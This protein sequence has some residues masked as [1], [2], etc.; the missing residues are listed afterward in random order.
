[1]TNN[2]PTITFDRSRE[3]RQDLAHKPNEI[4]FIIITVGGRVIEVVSV[5][6]I[7]LSCYSIDFYQFKLSIS[8]LHPT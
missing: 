6:F 1:M 4:V 3:Q 2:E 5:L 8:R 7:Q